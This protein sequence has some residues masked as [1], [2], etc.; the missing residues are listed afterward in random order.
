MGPGYFILA[1]MGCGDSA[2]MCEDIRQVEAVYR[3]EVACL[4]DSDNALQDSIEAPYPML[5]AECRQVSPQLAQNRVR[6]TG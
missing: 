4:A 6:I 2:V 3:S 1:I 5:M